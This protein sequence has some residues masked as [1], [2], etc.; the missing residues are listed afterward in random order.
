MLSLSTAMDLF[1]DCRT[2]VDCLYLLGC[3]NSAAWQP[4]E[5]V[6][7]ARAC[8]FR[9][10]NTNLL[11]V[12]CLKTMFLFDTHTPDITFTGSSLE[13]SNAWRI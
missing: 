9:M 1:R 7:I 5:L 13:V 4:T 2:P 10:Y 6:L 8:V 12:N 11:T 3:T